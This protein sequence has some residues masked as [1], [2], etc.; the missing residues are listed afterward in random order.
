M[1]VLYGAPPSP[2]SLS[3]HTSCFFFSGT[4][5][6]Q[7]TSE[8]IT[9]SDVINWVKLRVFHIRHNLLH[10]KLPCVKFKHLCVYESLRIVQKT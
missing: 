5:H 3:F 2:P 1:P 7:Q 10:I 6:L 9:H 8:F 4:F